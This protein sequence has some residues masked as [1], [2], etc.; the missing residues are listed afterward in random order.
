MPQIM[1]GIKAI[2]NKGR[3]KSKAQ[4]DL[5]LLLFID[6]IMG[7]AWIRIKRLYWL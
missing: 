3:K 1:R 6:V 2:R 7:I 5:T 4:L